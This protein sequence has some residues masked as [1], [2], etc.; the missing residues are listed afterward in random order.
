MLGDNVEKVLSLLGITHEK[1][2]RWVGAPCGCEERKQKLNALD[3]WARRV[4]A[5]RKAKAKSYLYSILG[6]EHE[7]T[8]SDSED[9]FPA[10]KT[11]GEMET[12]RYADLGNP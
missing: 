1:V 4:L 10:G 8:A 7:R 6:I 12:G 9:D 3:A 11:I 5:G 2:E